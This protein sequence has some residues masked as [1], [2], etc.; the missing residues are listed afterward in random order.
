MPFE[1][2]AERQSDFAHY[3]NPGYLALL[4]YAVVKGYGE[5]RGDMPLSLL[6]PAVSMVLHPVVRTALPKTVSTRFSKWLRDKPE[7]KTEILSTTGLLVPQ[8]KEGVLTALRAGWVSTE[9]G[10]L[11]LGT[12]APSV[13]K[14]D[15]KFASDLKSAALV[16]RWLAN[17]GNERE[18]YQHIGIR[19]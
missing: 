18:I 19:P 5:G 8:V 14:S 4:T 1:Q 11:T 13:S 16:G 15:D 17:S 2:W 12:A 9:N 6:F 3:F 10:L 7:V